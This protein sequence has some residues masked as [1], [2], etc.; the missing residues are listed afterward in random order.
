MLLPVLGWAQA[1]VKVR[2]EPDSDGYLFGT[3]TLSADGTRHDGF[4]RLSAPQQLVVRVLKGRNLQ[5]TSADVARFALGEKRYFTLTGVKLPGPQTVADLFDDKSGVT[6]AFVE[7]V[8][9]GRVVLLSYSFLS[10]AQ[11]H[12]EV[13]YYLLRQA[14]SPEVVL[15]PYKDKPFRELLRPYL[16]ARP[17]LLRYLDEKRLSISTLPDFI[18]SLNTGVSYLPPERYPRAEE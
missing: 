7:Q 1:Q 2:A 4:M 12:P 18:H 3:Y 9:S 6:R 14:G 13:H 5:Y 17:D 10:N 8:D 11:Y 15:V 16:Q